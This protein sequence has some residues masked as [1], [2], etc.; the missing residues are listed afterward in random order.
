MR[1]L[2][3]L[4]CIT[5]STSLTFAQRTYRGGRSVK[6]VQL[7]K[8]ADLQTQLGNEKLAKQLYLNAI[9]QDRNFTEAIDN[10]A[11]LYRM[12][13]MLDSAIHYY[14]T[15]LDTKPNGILARQNLAASYQLIGNYDQALETYH[16]LLAYYPNYPEA[17]YG[18]AKVYIDKKDY[19][20]GISH[21]EVALRKFM[22]SKEMV[23][24]ADARML[25]ARAYMLDRQYNTAKKYLKANKKYFEH[26]PFYHYYL[27]RCYAELDKTKKAE[28]Y[29]NQAKR[30]GYRLPTYV[31]VDLSSR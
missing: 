17:Y 2:F 5:C 6:A 4:L 16:E 28:K 22:Q 21:A 11:D 18:L 7:Y 26:K 14:R 15:S 24:A 31:E 10:L 3:V 8:R 12:N 30:M 13:G 29:L 9:H 25:A 27:G 20:R 1:I 23:R 19:F